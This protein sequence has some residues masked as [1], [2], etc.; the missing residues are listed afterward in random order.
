MILTT[1]R[2]GLGF[3]AVW[4]VIIVIEL[5]FTLVLVMMTIF[6]YHCIVI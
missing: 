1:Y 4:I 6:L 5:I 2:V 3:E